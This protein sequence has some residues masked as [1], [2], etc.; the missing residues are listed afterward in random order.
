MIIGGF[1]GRTATY[2]EGTLKGTYVADQT[3]LPSDQ[4]AYGIWWRNLGR[5]SV[6]G[7]LVVE[8]QGPQNVPDGETQYAFADAVRIEG[9]MP[10]YIVSEVAQPE[11]TQSSPAAGDHAI[12]AHPGESSRG[13]DFGNYQLGS[14]SGRKF[15]DL[16][17]DGVPDVGEPGLDGATIELVDADTGLL[18]DTQITAG[19]G[20]YSFTDLLP[21]NYEVRDTLDPLWVRSAPPDG[22]H[23]VSVLSGRDTADVNFGSFFV[24]APR[25]ISSSLDQSNLLTEGKLSYTA[26]FDQEVYQLAFSLVDPS[27]EPITPDSWNY[28]PATSTFTLDFSTP[29][30]IDT[31]YTLSLFCENIYGWDLDG[32]ADPVTIVP[33][34]DGVEGGDF[35]VEL[36][37]DVVTVPYP[38]SFE[39]VSPLGSLIYDS[40]PV[41][42]EISFDGDTDTYTIDIGAGMTIAAAVDS[43]GVF[44]PEIEL[45]DSSDAVIA[46]SW[47]S[48][49]GTVLQ[50]VAITTAGTYKIVV[51]GFQHRGAYDLQIILNAAVEEEA[52]GGG[53]NEFMGWAQELD[54]IA[55][56]LGPGL[57]DRL[58]VLGE[59]GVFS[60]YGDWYTFSLDD[61]ESLTA[62]L[63]FQDLVWDENQED[64]YFDVHL[65]L[66]D[67]AGNLLTAGIEQANAMQ[68]INDF[69]DATS[70][71]SPDMYYLLVEGDGPYFGEYSLTVTRSASFD[72]EV[73]DRLSQASDITSSGQAVGHIDGAELDRLFVYDVGTNVISELD[74]IDGSVLNSFS[75]PATPESY[76]DPDMSGGALATTPSTLL[77]AIGESDLYELAPDTGAVL[78]IIDSPVSTIDALAYLDGQIVISPPI[79]DSLRPQLEQLVQFMTNNVYFEPFAA[80][81]YVVKLSDANYQR[82]RADGWLSGDGRNNF[83]RRNYEDGSEQTANPYWLCYEDHGGDWD[84]KDVMIKVTLIGNG[85]LLELSAGFTGHRNYLVDMEDNVLAYIPSNTDLGELPPIS[86]TFGSLYTSM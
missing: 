68:A 21:G 61:G 59:L 12:F 22:S 55:V 81:P 19:G 51:G 46:S 72:R 9:G 37:S 47:D 20:M 6:T 78:R 76:W 23:A 10:S 65:E 85:A 39:A 70:N 53:H 30:G 2:A 83:P 40:Q 60:H 86:I 36:S 27:T 74:R 13:V 52:H 18:L 34:G 62:V 11:W 17:P 42:S 35:I 84:F 80:G 43:H 63:E 16:D 7:Q 26:V 33:S 41:T 67:G 5:H 66:Y 82:A 54:G 1:F 25:V 31:V 14:I 8:I 38:T 32:E 73:N 64:V 56:S 48:N 71:G 75:S 57:G 3:V 44:M 24:P 79:Y 77:F 29:P 4:Q 45:W 58:G 49:L 50:S 69:V 28:D 15:E